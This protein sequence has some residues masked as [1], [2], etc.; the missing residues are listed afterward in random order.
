MGWDGGAPWRHVASFAIALSLLSVAGPAVADRAAEARFHDELAREHYR[1][2]RYEEALREFFLHHRLAPNPLALYNIALCFERLDDGAHAF[3]FYAE[4]LASAADDPERRA[5]VEAAMA[6]LRPTLALVEVGSDPPGATIYVDRRDR[7]SYGV[8]PLVLPV[9]PGTR[10]LELELDGHHTAAVTVEAEV[11]ELVRV[12]PSLRRMLG[13]LVVE[14]PQGARVEVRDAEGRVAYEGSIPARS[15]LP[16]DDYT[17]EVTSEGFEAWRGLTRI[18][19][20]EPTVVRAENVALPPQ[21]G[22]LTVTASAAGA[23]IAIDGEPAGFAPAVLPE[24]ALG[25]HRVR[26]EQPGLQPWEGEVEV[27]AHERSWLTVTLESPP[28]VERS[29]AAWAIGGVAAAALV[30]AAVTGGV[31]LDQHARWI[32][33]ADLDAR[34][35]G[36]TLAI[37]TDVLLVSGIVGAVAAVVLWFATEHVDARASR[38]TVARGSR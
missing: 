17:V 14:G 27:V 32:D 29:P 33:G 23:L 34:A 38:G 9:T 1:A 10:E 6:R 35:T 31:A 28:T 36:E 22:D 18:V 8:T 25:V 3:L 12:Q 4:Y 7:G 16:P 2:R 13:T 19:V 26:V 30:G 20:D 5:R 24:L 11:G 37:T 21:T 15:E